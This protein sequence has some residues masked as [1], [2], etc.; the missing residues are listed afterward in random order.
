MFALQSVPCLAMVERGG[1]RC[2]LDEREIDS[3]VLG[4]AL[5]A[6][7]AG[8]GL[9]IVGRVQSTAVLQPRRNLG[10]ALQAFQFALGADLRAR[11]AVGRSF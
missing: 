4:V 5:G 2:P 1:G 11:G 6:A 9:Q 8:V 10:V 3:V 7:L